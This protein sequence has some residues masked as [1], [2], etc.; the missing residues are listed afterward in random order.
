M[1]SGD[2][3]LRC[4]LRSRSAWTGESDEGYARCRTTGCRN[5]ADDRSLFRLDDARVGARAVIRIRKL[6]DALQ[7]RYFRLL[8]LA[9]WL[10][11]V[12]GFAISAATSSALI[13]CL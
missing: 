11:I 2:A 10:W 9:A 12:L 7:E 1:G 3:S 8:Y 5:R 13:H 6:Q 4:V